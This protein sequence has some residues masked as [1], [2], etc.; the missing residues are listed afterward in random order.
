[1]AQPS[2]CAVLR[3]LP[4]EPEG[5]GAPLHTAGPYYFAEYV[6]GRRIVLRRNRFY[7]GSRPHHVDRI[8]VDLQAAGTGDAIQKVI[9][10]RADYMVVADREAYQR[11]AALTRRYGR[12]KV[13]VWGQP[14]LK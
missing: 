11:V 12:K 7:R 8:V 3:N 4:I 5:I 2:F 10:G 14:G 1:M 6:R 13:R 9:A